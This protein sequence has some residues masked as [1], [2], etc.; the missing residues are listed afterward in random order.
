MTRSCANSGRVAGRPSTPPRGSRALASAGGGEGRARR[1][2]R[3]TRAAGRPGGD[4]WAR[5]DQGSAPCH[6]RGSRAGRQGWR[7][8]AGEAGP[9]RG[10]TARD[11]AS[12]A[13][14][15]G[16]PFWKGYRYTCR[17]ALIRLESGRRSPS[18]NAGNS[19]KEE[20]G[21]RC[22]SEGTAA[23]LSAEHQGRV[24]CL[25]NHCVPVSSALDPGCPEVFG[26]P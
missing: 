1:C 6:A 5:R 10:Q 8:R 2:R 9:G 23:A 17:L 24:A 19:R 22:V 20:G 12:A 11:L 16:Q 25:R 15:R 18:F 4:P 13:P 3:A 26:S 7:T 14:W 21:P